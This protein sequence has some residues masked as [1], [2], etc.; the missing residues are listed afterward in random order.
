M[1]FKNTVFWRNN[2]TNKRTRSEEKTGTRCCTE[3]IMSGLEEFTP[4]LPSN[5]RHTIANIVP[6]MSSQ[7]VTPRQP[8]GRR[9][10]LVSFTDLE[11]A[12]MKKEC[13]QQPRRFSVANLNLKD[14]SNIRKR[15]DFDVLGGKR[16]MNPLLSALHSKNDLAVPFADLDVVG[17]NIKKRVKFVD[18]V[19][20]SEAPETP[21]LDPS[22]RPTKKP[23]NLNNMAS[24]FTDLKGQE[25]KRFTAVKSLFN[26][27]RNVEEL[28]GKALVT[29]NSNTEE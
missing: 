17:S 15:L 12:P 6:C 4:P 1:C 25:G 5:R 18:E 28:S 8:K 9:H 20:L 19:V 14:S 24:I 29:C 26:M 13:K 22:F 27:D 3:L 10:S 7:F 23:L 16:K 11:K 2:F 21:V